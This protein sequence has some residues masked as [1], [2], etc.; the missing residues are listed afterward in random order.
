MCRQSEGLLLIIASIINHHHQ[1]YHQS[2]SSALSSSSSSSPLSSIIR[3]LCETLWKGIEIFKI[4]ISVWTWEDSLSGRY[5][6]KYRY[7]QKYITTNKN[8]NTNTRKKTQRQQMRIQNVGSNLCFG[9]GTLF[10][11]RIP[12]KQSSLSI[13]NHYISQLFIFFSAPFTLFFLSGIYLG[14]FFNLP[15]EYLIL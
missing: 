14:Y 13:H 11:W 12:R 5:K 6:Y 8:T 7:K 1:H 15:P 10:V 2:S 4:A 9:L 3:I